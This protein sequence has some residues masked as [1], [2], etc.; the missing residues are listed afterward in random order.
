[1]ASWIKICPVC[2]TEAVSV[3]AMLPRVDET[4]TVIQPHQYA[5]CESCYEKQK[6]IYYRYRASVAP[7]EPPPLQPLELNK[8][9]VDVLPRQ[10]E[11]ILEEISEEIPSELAYIPTPVYAQGE[12]TSEQ[13]ESLG[14][15]FRRWFG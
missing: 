1:M 12:P 14:E 4:G 10:K 3:I 9:L 5:V 11:F 6:A 8:P 15:K 2:E 7:V 13:K